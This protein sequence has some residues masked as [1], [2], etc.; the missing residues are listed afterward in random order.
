MNEQ[1]KAFFESKREEELKKQQQMDLKRQQ[2]DLKR[3][4]MDKEN[5]LIKLG[6][7]EKV[8]A[9]SAE[10]STGYPY[11]EFDEVNGVAKYYKKVPIKIT[12]EKY[13]E[14]QNYFDQKDNTQDEKYARSNG[15]NFIATLLTVIAWI[16]YVS[17]LICGMFYGVNGSGPTFMLLVC[18][19]SA[20]V[21]GTM[22]YGFAEIIRLLT[23][24][25]N[26]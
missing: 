5:T 26:K 2:M 13:K 25:K 24:I 11:Y 22:Y 19:I 9:P 21:I 3:Q 18:W 17:G 10:E 16:V 7:F 4:Q 12:D 23:E 8:Y 6:L 15:N 1:L 20:F 14:I